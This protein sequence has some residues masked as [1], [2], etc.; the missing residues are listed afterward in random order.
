MTMPER[1]DR[2]PAVGAVRAVTVAY[3]MSR[4]P[5]LTETF[6]LDEILALEELGIRVELFPLLRQREAVV[7]PE[8]VV[9]AARARYQPFLSPAILA[10]QFHY[11]ARRPRAYLGALLSL[12]FRTLGS[13][14]YFVGGLAVFPKVVHAA[15]L[16]EAEGVEHVH[17][18]FANH[19]AAG[20]FV[21]HRLTGIPFS[22]TAHGSDL[23]RDRH[24]LRE[25]VAEAETVVT[26][27]DYNRRLILDECGEEFA[28]KVVVVRC[29]VDTDMF[30][31][32]PRPP[33]PSE[34]FRV[35]CIASFDE[36]KG[37][38]YLVEACR[39]L[40]DSGV[41]IDCRLVGDG[42]MRP[43]VARRVS[44]LEL[45]G[46]VRFEGPKTRQEVAALLA[47]TDVAACPS[48][49]TSLGDREGIPVVLMEAMAS[50]VPVV[51]SD[52]SGIPELVEHEFTGLLVPPG[53]AGA[54]AEA[55]RRLHDDPDLRRRLAAAGRSR[56]LSEHDVRR[57]A[58][59]LV[60]RLVGE[61]T[62]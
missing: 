55:L 7:H 10:T 16:M 58:R 62:A 2:P 19:P 18:H 56:A 21:I 6:I 17:C 45:E 29:G 13:R 53:E 9:L 54:L 11:L 36:V 14:N 61:E 40:L 25:K 24:M 23:H 31:P 35:V 28:D 44:Q 27:S 37:Q 51:A 52:I 3:L 5:K 49:W 33:S 4:F 34:R 41:D 15:R 48:V 39:L 57:H 20:G 47:D 43:E 30:C 42:P 50:G 38:Q 59:A 60:R 46:V 32:R 12:A 26:I 1:V 8:A 22:F